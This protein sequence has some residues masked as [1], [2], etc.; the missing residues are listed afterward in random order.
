L[1]ALKQNDE[2][3][4]GAK[5]PKGATVGWDEKL[6]V[7]FSCAACRPSRAP[8]A[9]DLRKDRNYYRQLP[10]KR[11]ITLGMEVPPEGDGELALVLAETLE[12]L[13]ATQDDED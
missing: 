9:S 1:Q 10:V 7:V 4:C 13:L 6:G 5:L 2:C 8:A 3:K 12:E 11:L